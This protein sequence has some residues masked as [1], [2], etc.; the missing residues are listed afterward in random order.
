VLVHVLGQPPQGTAD[1]S[2][3]LDY[4]KLDVYRCAIGLLDTLPEPEL[5]A[6]KLLL[7]RVVGMLSKMCR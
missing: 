2:I 6:A 3:M 1:T 7:I 5:V 4:E